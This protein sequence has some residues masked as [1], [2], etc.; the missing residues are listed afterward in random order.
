MARHCYNRTESDAD[1]HGALLAASEY[2]LDE[3]K[4]VIVMSGSR[5]ERNTYAE[6]QRSAE[7]E[8]VGNA[9]QMR[10]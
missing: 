5:E 6:T 2:L 10:A 9:W 4:R 3:A 1:D 7:E 8:E